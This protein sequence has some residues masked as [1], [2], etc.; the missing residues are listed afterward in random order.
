MD[1]EW[2]LK[3]NAAN[4]A[5]HGFDFADA[6]AVFKGKVLAWLDLRE[7]YGEDRWQG[8]GLLKGKVVALVWT[9]RPPNNRVRIISFR[10][11]GQHERETYARGIKDGLGSD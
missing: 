10:K 6:E 4:I 7:D 5:K 8:F 9:I 1:F 3:K 11:A 2:D